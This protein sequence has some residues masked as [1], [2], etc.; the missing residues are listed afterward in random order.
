MILYRLYQVD[1]SAYCF[2]CRCI[3][4]TPTKIAQTSKATITVESENFLLNVEQLLK[5]TFC[6]ACRESLSVKKSVTQ[7]HISSAKHQAD[8]KGVQGKET[9]DG[10]IASKLKRHDSKSHLVVG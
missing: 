8:K 7:L 5:V 2:K 10:D 3:A 6:T 9:R 1:L 4:S